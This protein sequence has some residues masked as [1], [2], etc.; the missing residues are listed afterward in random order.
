MSKI[1]RRLANKQKLKTLEWT[2]DAIEE[3]SN[4]SAQ[5][6]IGRNVEPE[7]N[8]CVLE[9]NNCEPENSPR[10]SSEE[11]KHGTRIAKSSHA[12]PNLQSTQ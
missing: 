5:D 6:M 4:V 3:F 12:K 8:N 7:N 10:S 9:N 2:D 1:N 11:R